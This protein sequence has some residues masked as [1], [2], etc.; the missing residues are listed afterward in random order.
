MP[1]RLGHDDKNHGQRLIVMV[2]TAGVVLPSAFVVTAS[3]AA[4]PFVEAAQ[5]ERP[6]KL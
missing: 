1:L 4:E 2:V 3:K 6:L 5:V